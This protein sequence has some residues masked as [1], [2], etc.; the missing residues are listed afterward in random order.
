MVGEPATEQATCRSALPSTPSS[1]SLNASHGQRV[2]R[3]QRAALGGSKQGL[4]ADVKSRRQ[5]DGSKRGS[6]HAARAH[7]ADKD[8]ARKRPA[9]LPW[10][11]TTIRAL[12]LLVACSALATRFWCA[13]RDQD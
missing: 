9:P 6:R 2:Q 3:V 1:T 7:R 5:R 12:L 13:W 10:Y 4:E 11:V 8:A